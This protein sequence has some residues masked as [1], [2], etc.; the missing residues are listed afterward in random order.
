MQRA[1]QRTRGDQPAGKE[2]GGDKPTV[3]D[4]PGTDG[5]SKEMA[6]TLPMRRAQLGLA[7]PA[8][9]ELAAMPVI[10]KV[11]TVVVR[12]GTLSWRMVALRKPMARPVR[13]IMM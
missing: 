2:E 10:V 3:R 5:G 4:E 12:S 1:G 11:S 6:A 9:L 7:P 13:A 8:R